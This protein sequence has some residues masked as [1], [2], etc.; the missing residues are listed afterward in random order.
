MA[1]EETCSP[2]DMPQGPSGVIFSEG[3]AVVSRLKGG[4]AVAR[5]S[6][7]D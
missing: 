2:L 1:E 6:E 3:I 5:L 7:A 4:S